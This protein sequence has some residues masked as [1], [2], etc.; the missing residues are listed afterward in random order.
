MPF[1]FVYDHC[2]FSAQCKVTYGTHAVAHVAKDLRE[3]GIKKVLGFVARALWLLGPRSSLAGLDL[4]CDLDALVLREAL[5]DVR[6][7]RDALQDFG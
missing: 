4:C 1:Y 3:D 2:P 5:G 6:L 7:G